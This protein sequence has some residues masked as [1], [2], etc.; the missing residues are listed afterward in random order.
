MKTM[1]R[2]LLVLLALV[3]SLSCM[4][5]TVSAD[6]TVASGTCGSNLTWVLTD[7]GTLTV[8]GSG[9]M[10][11]YSYYP[12]E[13]PW[14]DYRSSI[15][16]V[17]IKKGVTSIGDYAFYNGYV[18]SVSIPS[19]VT[20]IGYEAFAYNMLTSVTIPS[21]VTSIEGYA[22]EC[23]Y[24]LSTITFKGSAPSFGNY[25][26]YSVTAN[27]Y[28]PRSES[29]SWSTYVNGYYIGGSLNWIS[30]GPIDAPVVTA[31]NVASSGKIKLSWNA[32]DGAVAYKVMY[33]T[34]KNGSYEVLKSRT[35]DTSLTHSKAVAGKTYYYK[36]MALAEDSDNNSGYST[37]VKKC[38]DLPR[39]TLDVTNDPSTG[40]V[41]LSWDAVKG[42]YGYKVYYSTSKNGS[43]SV[44]K[45]Y[46]NST[47]LTHSKAVAGTTYYY[48]VR[49]LADDSA[50]DSADS[51]IVKCACDLARPTVTVSNDAETG[52]VVLKWD[53]VSNA[54][55][56]NIFRATSK[57]GDYTCIKSG[58][59]ARTYTDTSAR[60]GRTYYYKVRAV[61][62]NSAANSAHSAAVKAICD[63]A[64]P[65]V[66]VSSS[67]LSSIKI[68]WN[69]VAGADN[70]VV[71]R[72]TSKNSGYKKLATTDNNSYTDKNVSAGKTYYYKVKA[73]ADVSAANSQFSA[74]ISAK[75]SISAPTMKNS[76]TVT[77]S[78]IKISWEKV[79][80]ASGYYV[81]RRASTDDSWSRIKT[82][83][84][85][86]TSFTDEDRSGR[87]YYCVAAYKTVNGIT[88]TSEKSEAIRTRTLGK[89]KSVEAEG[90]E[91]FSNDLT[92]GK[93]NGATGYQVYYKIGED[94]SWDRAD[95]VTGTSYNHSVT[96]GVY[97]YYKVRAIYQNDGVTSY[98]PFVEADEG[99]INFY[100]PNIDIWM[101]S[102]RDSSTS[103]FMVYVTNNGVAP[104]YFYS[105]GAKSY[106]WDY[107][108][109]NRDLT[110]YDYNYYNTY[111]SFRTASY[112]CIQPGESGWVLLI[113][114]TN[115]WYDYKTRVYM[116]AYY[117]G[118]WYD[119]YSSY[120]LGFNYY[121]Q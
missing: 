90:G 2:T 110:M 111:G 24:S 57:N 82:V 86:T 95:T 61:A 47:S 65:V 120:Y 42:A 81:Y 9:A 17:V 10:Y 94:G 23:N 46:T 102:T 22:F 76:A 83:N 63:C 107:S 115:T 34:S 116:Q 109:Y 73:Q 31:E 67:S 45:S 32:V 108:T 5:F 74:V 87:Y 3:L 60:A 55:S 68:S 40:K 97:Y 91:G 56:Y 36:V 20:S 12:D 78:T 54:V 21:S 30:S 117:D 25:P 66:K 84:S 52:K 49:V 104:I 118:M 14:D 71:Y 26:F 58:V 69:S 48:K 105:D 75:A 79:S 98:G 8:S 39:T 38:C 4:L 28:Y 72:S 51:A 89:P 19:T 7:D 119:T 1:K 112:T 50:A 43:Y 41:K 92:W 113:S 96:H 114:D 70:Y 99:W 80:G 59:T 103:V 16:K 100:Y 53:K 6:E 18:S 27:V 106:D 121:K 29:S 37:V 101:S 88:Y 62:E 85:S 64:Q 44:L 35:T 11:D 13:A 15:T 33:S 93:V 77:S